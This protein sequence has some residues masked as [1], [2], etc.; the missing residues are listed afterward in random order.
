MIHK[1]LKVVVGYPNGARMMNEEGFSCIPELSFPGG[2]LI[3]FSA[4][5]SIFLVLR[6][7]IPL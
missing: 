4:G 5:L 2:V 6:D 7:L 3:G 1:Y